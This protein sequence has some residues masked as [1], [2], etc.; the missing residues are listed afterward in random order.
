MKKVVVVSGGFDPVHSGHIAMFKAAKALGDVLVVALNSDDWLT[1]KKGQPFMPWK[2]RMSIIKELAVVDQVIEFD[3]SDNTACA[4]LVD[5]LA[6]WESH[7]VL[8]ANGGDRGKDNIPEMSVQDS[9]LTF[10]FGVGGND[11]KNSSSWI[12]KEW[13]QPTTQRAWGSYTVLHNGPG[14]AVKELAF[15]T[16]TPL[17]DQRHFI[18]SE[19]WHVIEGTIRMDLEYPNG[20]KESKTYGPGE[21]VDIPVL[22]WHKAYNIG[23]KIAKVIEVWMGEKLT[24]DD[25]ER[26]D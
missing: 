11:K 24:E 23:S 3:D 26:R 21:S 10:E 25:I 13:S 19:H 9:R 7:P 15:G 5:T 6:E 8:F 4:A 16:N 20:D 2:E 12:L 1:R 14:W 18:R 17:S 22:T